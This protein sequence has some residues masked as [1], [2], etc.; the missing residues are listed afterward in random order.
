VENTDDT[1]IERNG[2]C[3][4]IVS[5]VQQQFWQWCDKKKHLQIQIKWP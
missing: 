4:W 2:K 1:A 3:L 5:D